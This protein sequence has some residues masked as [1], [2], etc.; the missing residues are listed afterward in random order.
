MPDDVLFPLGES[1]PAPALPPGRPRLQLPV[2][3]QVELAHGDLDSFVPD[4][5]PVRIVWAFVERVDVGVLYE[6][7]LA[8]EGR[9][10]RAPIDPRIL[11]ALWIFATLRAIGSARELDRLCSEHVAYRWICGGV[12]VNYHTLADFRSESGNIFDALLTESVARLRAAGLVSMDRVAHD[13]L[14]T[15]ADAGSGSFFSA[16]TL[17]VM[18]REA[19][20]QVEALRRELLDDPTA[21]SRRQRAARTRAAQEMLD[22]VN[23]AL[24]QIP[25]VE[26]HKKDPKKKARASITDAQARSMKMPNG[27]FNPAYNVQLSADTGSQI[28]VG[29]GVSQCGSDHALLVPAVEE[30]QARTGSVPKEILADGGFG[31]LE[32]VETL[33]K[34]PFEC[35][36]YAPPTQYKDKDGNVKEPKPNE[37]P[38]IK[39]WRGRMATAEAQTIYKERAST[40]ECVNALARN[41]GLR[42]VRVRGMEKVKA[43]VL[44]FAL[45]HNFAR[46][47][48][49][50]K[51]WPPKTG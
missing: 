43:V 39:K 4:D 48:S 44:I 2:R 38:E 5:H 13:G 19:Q 23:A 6:H 34:E 35:T 25:D 42:Q 47:E 51:A 50:K 12:P 11:L 14:R 24:A 20:E 27:G 3:N 29:V 1:R 17:E 28:I 15:R 30:I 40:I 32:A 37:A 36:V 7:I 46:E 22:R 45:V 10:G 31:K 16:E 49:L 9:A 18:R 41:R 21:G 8:V 33:S 26:A